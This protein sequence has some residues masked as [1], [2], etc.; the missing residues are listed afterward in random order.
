MQGSNEHYGIHC[1]LGDKLV[2]CS[3]DFNANVIAIFI[4]IRTLWHTVLIQVFCNWLRFFEGI[5]LGS[6]GNQYFEVP[7]LSEGML[8]IFC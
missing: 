7:L 4:K 8:T 5:G 3:L 1:M 2:E 6:A